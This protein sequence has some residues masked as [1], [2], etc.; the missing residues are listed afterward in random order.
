MNKCEHKNVTSTAIRYCPDC[1]ADCA[2]C[3]EHGDHPAPYGK[4][5]C[6]IACEI[7]DESESPLEVECA[8]LCRSLC[9]YCGNT[10]NNSACQRLHP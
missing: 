4:R 9:T 2:N 7:C 10:K 1:G 6:S 3:C 8:G 5:F